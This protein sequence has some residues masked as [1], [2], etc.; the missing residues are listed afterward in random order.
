[1]D[2][3][4]WDVFK[5]WDYR[6]VPEINDLAQ[7]WKV[8]PPLFRLFEKCYELEKKEILQLLEIWNKKLESLG[9]DPTFINWT[10]FRPLQMKREEDWS[11]WL[12][13]LIENSKTGYFSQALF[14]LATLGDKPRMIVDRETEKDGHRADLVIKCGNRSHVH[15]EVKIGDPNLEK[16]YETARKMRNKYHADLASWADFILLLESQVAQW[17]EIKDVGKEIIPYITWENVAV[18]LRASLLLSDEPI[19][20]KSWAY[21]FLGAIEQILLNHPYIDPAKKEITGYYFLDSMIT[22]LKEVH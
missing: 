9:G 3:K 15:V 22:V 13:H 20:W 14:G 19:P 12:A 17:K 16:T 21:A 1:M 8:F 18:A 10:R 6:P 5:N 4:A 2:K 11:D 7:G